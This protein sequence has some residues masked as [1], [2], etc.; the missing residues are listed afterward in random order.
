MTVHVFFC[1]FCRIEAEE[2]KL[3]TLTLRIL[4]EPV[5]M[6]VQTEISLITAFLLWP[7]RNFDMASKCKIT[8]CMAHLLCDVHSHTKRYYLRR[9]M[10]CYIPPSTNMAVVT[11]TLLCN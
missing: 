5:E 11:N 2:K 7:V 4:L 8:F 9:S 1:T 6:V 10:L 3:I